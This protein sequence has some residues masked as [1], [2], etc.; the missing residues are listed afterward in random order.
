MS[1]SRIIKRGVFLFLFTGLLFFRTSL[2]CQD[3]PVNT[4]SPFSTVSTSIKDD[5]S[6]EILLGGIQDER[7]WASIPFQAIETDTCEIKYKIY[8]DNSHIHVLVVFP[9]PNEKLQ[10]R[11]WHWNPLKQIYVAGQEKEEELY[12]IW[13]EFPF[14]AVPDAFAEKADVWIWRAART[15][16]S[17]FADD[18][19]FINN[20]ISRTS[21]NEYADL[22][23]DNG[24]SC[25]HD[26]FFADFA[27]NELPRYKQ[28][29]PQGSLADVKAKGRWESGTWTI[30]FSRKINTGN[31]DD[32]DFDGNKGLAVSFSILPPERKSLKRSAFKRVSEMK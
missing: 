20:T 6:S 22:L 2:H 11:P 13:S 9:S 15:D 3:I 8:R 31:P 7:K 16:P 23:P 21:D 12:A 26:C 29:S 19:H 28:R 4:P 25:W 27:G 1:S 17:G 30:E 24:K 14:D 5:S 10:H 18:Y 32:I